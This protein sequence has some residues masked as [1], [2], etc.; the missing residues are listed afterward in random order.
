MSERIPH[1]RSV[2]LGIWVEAGTR[3]ELPEE[4]GISHFIEHMMFKG[5]SRRTAAE[6]AESLEAVGG[7]LNAF[8]GKEVTCYYAHHLDEHLA[9]AIDVV[10]DL[11]TGSLFDQQELAKEK[12]VVIEEIEGP[13]ANVAVTA[14]RPDGDGAVAVVQSYSSSAVTEQ[15]VFTVDGRRLDAVA[16][17]LSPG[18]NAEARVT[19]GALESGVLSAAID[20]REGFHADNVRFA[21]LSSS[22]GAERLDS[23]KR[24]S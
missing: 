2:S 17:T 1:V 19:N 18:G 24:V 16:V 10:T 13:A 6:I 12:S 7:N 21:G 15:V 22:P 11:L 23:Q 5:T 9:I 20:D 8:T 4:N 14:V 3:D